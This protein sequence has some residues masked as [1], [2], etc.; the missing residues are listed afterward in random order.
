M[1]LKNAMLRATS[2]SL[3]AFAGIG[4]FITSAVAQDRPH[5]RILFL[6]PAPEQPED[7]A[8]VIEMTDR[9]RNR[10]QNKFRHKWQVIQRDVIQELLINSGFDSLAIVGPEM[11][12][13]FARPLQAHSYVYGW[14]TR[15]GA[16]PIA[17]Y[18]M[19]D[20][21][22]TGLSGWMTV[23]GQP[24]D[25]PN[26]FADRVVDSLENQVRAA[27]KAKE[28]NMRRDRSEF[29]RARE[30][31]DQAFAY[32]ENHPSTTTCLSYVFQGMQAPDDSLV[33]VYEKATRGDS[34][35]QRAWQDLARAY[36]RAG[37]TAGAVVALSMQLAANPTDTI[38]RFQLAAG[39][40][41]TQNYDEALEI[42]DVGLT[43][44][45]ESQRF[46]NLKARACREGEMW[47]CVL[48]AQ[49]RMYELNTDLVGDTTFYPQ[50]FA[51]STTVG[52]TSAMLRWA[53]LALEYQPSDLRFLQARGV[54]LRG[55]GFNDS[56]LSVYERIA[57][58]DP[59]N[60]NSVI[61]VVQ[62]HA[63]AF[64]VDSVTPVDTV[65]Q[66]R[67]D[68]ELENLL[69][70]SDNPGIITTVG[71]EYLKLAQKFGQAGID[72]NVVI[73]YAERA[74]EHDPNGLLDAAANFWLGYGVFQVTV[75][76]DAQ[77]MEAQTCAP[78]AAYERNLRRA[79]EALNAGRS[80]A[81]EAADQFLDY[82][83]QLA[84]RPEQ[85]RASFCGG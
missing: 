40:V 4:L 1:Q 52:D 39:H 27:D 11:A 74:L 16:T 66:A 3:L 85:F 48:E 45:P 42:L 15:N 12:E 72:W 79:T 65:A 33:W 21:S 17:R 35:N 43:Q 18:R 70:L 6:V 61:F 58:L 67:L 77:I 71:G 8:W 14:L 83:A 53:T 75:P 64:T 84:E 82:L 34:L 36:Q 50:M 46:L 54:L 49:S 76:M 56:A 51:L 28:C 24:G 22:R 59:T 37:D 26:S 19:V 31:A 60:L 78:I 57:E 30:A 38:M 20:V 29:R 2:V 10:A 68:G 55:A 69:S 62:A 80:V 81:P 23:Q 7:S 25:P 47:G 9:L 41:V 5:D 44:Y 32:Y 73:Q 63:E 13:Q